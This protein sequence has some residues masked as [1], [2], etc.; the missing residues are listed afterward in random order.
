MD[1]DDVLDAAFLASEPSV[2]D[3]DRHPVQLEEPNDLKLSA[4]DSRSDVEAGR[5]LSSLSRWDRIPMATFRRTRESRGSISNDDAGTWGSPSTDHDEF[6]AGAIMNMP[7]HSMIPQTPK[8]QDREA[9][10]GNMLGSPVFLND[11]DQ[12]ASNIR[13]IRNFHTLTKRYNHPT[14]SEKEKKEEKKLKQKMAHK[15]SKG[16]GKSCSPQH[17]PPHH[18]HQHHQHHPNSKSRASS[19]MQRN[20]FNTS[21][22][23]STNS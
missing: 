23:P 17:Q 10:S 2:S 19:S 15:T 5:H 21:T 7:L 22:L 16:K 20:N 8:Q 11:G 1:L 13:N 3:V 4:E 6:Y 9:P 12:T 18:R 14:K